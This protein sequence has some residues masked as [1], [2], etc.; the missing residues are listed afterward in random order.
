[1]FRVVQPLLIAELI[2]A[3]CSL[4]P[5]SKKG[6]GQPA[7]GE[8]WNLLRQPSSFQ[9]R[10]GKNARSNPAPFQVVQ[11]SFKVLRI[12]L[13]ADRI[14][15]SRK[16]WNHVDESRVEPELTTRLVRNGLRVGAAAPGA[17]PAIATVLEACGART[18]EDR[19]VAQSNL[20]VTI[21]ID[22]IRDPESIFLYERSHALVGKTFPMGEKLITLEYA[23]RPE[24]G[25]CTDLQVE[26]EVR[27]DLQRMDWEHHDGIVRQVPAM[28]RHV[29]IDLKAVLT[30]RPSEFLVIGPSEKADH[31]YLVGNRFFTRQDSGMEPY[32]TLFCITPEPFSPHAGQRDSS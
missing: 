9:E 32:E 22:T 26:L 2:F 28:D 13:P 29:F 31:T 30:L 24:L 8:T 19:L 15:H 16:I 21:I 5:R 14:R 4:S 17:W 25:G 1:M 11:I 27:H 18:H 10:H 7:P 6:E 3:G 12:D 23:Y 20:P